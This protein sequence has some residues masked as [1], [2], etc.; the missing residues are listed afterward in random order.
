MMISENKVALIHYTLRNA[1]GDVIDSSEGNEPLPYLHGHGN[2]IPGLEKALIGKAV[3]DKLDV[4]V[5]PEEGYGERNDALTQVM[6]KEAFQGVD[7]LEPGMQFYAQGQ[8]GGVQT[9]T[10][11][12]VDGNDVTI[13]GNHPLAGETLSFQVEVVEVREASAE[14]LEHGHVH[15]VDGAESCE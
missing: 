2:I 14:E 13:D 1:A 5:S 9:V 7:E 6:P 15:G 11:V 10:I 4:N 12:A 3:G 8:D